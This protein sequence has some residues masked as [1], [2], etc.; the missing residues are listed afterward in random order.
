MRVETGAPKASAS[1]RQVRVGIEGAH[2]GHV[3]LRE[4]ALHPR[5]AG[6]EVV[7]A[8]ARCIGKDH[9]FEGIEFPKST[10]KLA[11]AASLAPSSGLA[12][13]LEEAITRSHEVIQVKAAIRYTQRERICKLVSLVG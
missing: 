12:G 10:Q 8:H 4:D 3:G 11:A 9:S 5:P 13:R 6:E 2:P 1:A 7:S